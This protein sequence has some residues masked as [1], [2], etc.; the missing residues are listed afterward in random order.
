M[1]TALAFKSSTHVVDILGNV[2]GRDQPIMLTAK[3][4]ELVSTLGPEVFQDDDVVFFDPFCKAGEILLACAI[5]RCRARFE[6]SISSEGFDPLNQKNREAVKDELYRSNRYFALAPDKRHY[7]LSLR[8]FLG[9]EN[10]HDP[11]FNHI[12]R[13]GDYLSEVD[14]RLDRKKFESE[15]LSMLEYIKSTAGEKKIVA[16]GNPPYQE[17]DG[18]FGKSAKSIYDLFTEQLIENSNI[19]EFALVIPARWFG[20][21]KGLDGFRN[22]MMSSSNIRN[23]RYFQN[24]SDVFPTVDINGGICFLHFDKNHDEKTIFTDGKFRKTVDFQEFDI[25]PDDPMAFALIKKIQSIWAGKYVGDVAWARKPFG[26]ETN[27]FEKNEELD[28]EDSTAVP[29]LCRGKKI[30]FAS[31][32]QVNKNKDKI[33]L[34]KVSAPAVGG[35]SKGSR[36]STIPLNQIFGVDKGCKTTETYNI[37]D[38]FGEKSQAENLITY[39]KTDFARYL[40]GLRKLTQHIPRDRWNWVPYMD[41]DQ[42]WTDEALFDFFKITKE[43][44]EHIKTKVK[45]WS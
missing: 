32:D 12:I 43:E 41:V 8:T 24:S 40:L 15:F 5:L 6:S 14:G 27:Y 42:Q 36:R 21:G 44:Q 23:L 4:I 37:I 9:N 38:V 26:L 16:V 13:N 11:T 3:A 34:W 39:L 28:A 45:E 2:A 33:D 1:S 30:K 29:C 22:R 31:I 7:R 17:T 20:G 25:I 19:S 35:G 10:S 18:G